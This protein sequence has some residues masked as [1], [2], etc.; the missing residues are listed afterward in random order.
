MSLR[1]IVHNTLCDPNYMCATHTKRKKKKKE[2][3]EKRKKNIRK[4]DKGRVQLK[5]NLKFSRFSGW[6]GMEKSIFQI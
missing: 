1:K 2:E 3:K 6:V 5:K 4:K